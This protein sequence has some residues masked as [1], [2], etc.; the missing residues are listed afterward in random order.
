MQLVW[1]MITIIII[2]FISHVQEKKP[3]LAAVADSIDMSKS[4]GMASDS[5][6]D[7]SSSSSSSSDESS[8]SESVS[9]SGQ[10]SLPEHKKKR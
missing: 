7:S 4:C 10:E 3:D 8:S 2:S 9:D 1:V 5:S 6:S